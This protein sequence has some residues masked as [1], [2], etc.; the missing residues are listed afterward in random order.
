[1]ADQSM[2]AS[3]FEKTTSL[4]I[5]ASVCCT[6]GSAGSETPSVVTTRDVVVAT[7]VA[8]QSTAV[9]GDCWLV[10]MTAVSKHHLIGIN[11]NQPD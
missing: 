8:R 10:D 1:M 4:D 5:D 3:R 2:A 7:S 11:I 9:L 6:S